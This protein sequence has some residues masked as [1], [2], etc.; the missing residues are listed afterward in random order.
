METLKFSKLSLHNTVKISL[1]LS[2][3][4]IPFLAKTDDHS[5]LFSAV[6]VVVA[7]VVEDLQHLFAV[8]VAVLNLF[9][10][11][12]SVLVE[13]AFVLGFVAGGFVAF[14]SERKVKKNLKKNKTRETKKAIKRNMFKLLSV[15]AVLNFEGFDL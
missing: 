10:A 12:C 1:K 4:K 3:V 5:K 6:A 7:A 11:V 9:V 8:A 14:G 13:V 2:M 15:V